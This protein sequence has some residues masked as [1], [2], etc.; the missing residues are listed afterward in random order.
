MAAPG[1]S[2]AVARRIVD[3][4]V[5]FSDE[6]VVSKYED[7]RAVFGDVVNFFFIWMCSVGNGC[8]GYG[9][10]ITQCNKWGAHCKFVFPGITFVKFNSTV[11]RLKL[12]LHR[13]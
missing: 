2:N 12:N 11:G 10:Q 3:D 9:L 8:L 1:Q 5:E 6:T 4:L 7:M 13:K